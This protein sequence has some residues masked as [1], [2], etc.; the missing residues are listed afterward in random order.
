M[1]YIFTLTLT[2]ICIFSISTITLA[3]TENP[4]EGSEQIGKVIE[5]IK[6]STDGTLEQFNQLNKVQTVKIKIESGDENGKIIT[7]DNVLSGNP[8]YDIPV[9]KGDKVI[10]NV[11]NTNGKKEYNVENLYRLPML[12]ILLSIFVLLVLIFGGKTGLKSLLSLAFTYFLIFYF[13]IPYILDGFPPLLITILVSLVATCATIFIITGINSKSLSAIIGTIGG[14]LAAGLM[15]IITI[16][17]APLTG[18]PNHEAIGLWTQFPDLDFKGIL[19]SAMII[20]ALGASMDVAISI[21]SSMYEVKQ[22]NTLINIKELIKSGMNVGK[23]V[24]GTMTNTLLLAYTG[25]GIFL[26][27]I[28]YNNV[29]VLKLLNLDSVVTEIT[30]ALAGSIGLVLCIPITAIVGGYLIGISNKMD[31]AKNNAN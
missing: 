16:K 26:I 18:L 27:L 7:T 17:L 4:D 25:S 3:Q 20:G 30:A 12:L 22:A 21:A 5:I 9:K 10:L 6:E 28:A 19:A 1:R 31:A 8:A 11:E 13:L 24:M 15:A 23:D 2:I 29:S 14:V